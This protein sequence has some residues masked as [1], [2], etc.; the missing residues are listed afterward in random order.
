MKNDS[1]YE[2]EKRI[3]LLRRKEATLFGTEYGERLRC[4]FLMRN[5]GC[6]SG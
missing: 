2:D 6:N 5:G 3:E 4:W 1:F